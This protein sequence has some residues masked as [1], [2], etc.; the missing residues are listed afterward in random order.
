MAWGDVITFCAG[1][2]TVIGAVVLI[3]RTF[4]KRLVQE[5]CDFLGWWR[6]FQR[7]WDGEPAS[8]GRSSVPGV[9]ERLNMIDGE[10]T[11]NGGSSLKDQV[12]LVR[13]KIDAMD[14][15]VD[16][17]EIRQVEMQRLLTVSPRKSRT[18]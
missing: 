8:P 11:R 16:T 4:L 13:D 12:I 15:R 14:K 2:V 5:A 1:V 6:K 3:Y 9:M 18:G 10:L 7:D 17:I